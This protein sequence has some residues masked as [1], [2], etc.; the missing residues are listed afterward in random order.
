V[1]GQDAG[2]V[3]LLGAQTDACV[4]ATVKGALAA[5]PRVTVVADAHSTWPHGG[6]TAEQIITRHNAEFAAL[7]VDLV[8]TKA[9]TGA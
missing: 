4:A 3:V 6:E 8:T 9:L 1:V 2:E 5:G 7:G